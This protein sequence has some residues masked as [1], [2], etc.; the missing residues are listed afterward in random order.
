MVLN[1]AT[2]HGLIEGSVWANNADMDAACDTIRRVLQSANPAD[3][4]SQFLAR[5]V[6]PTLIPALHRLLELVAEDMQKN[7]GSV[8]GFDGNA[9]ARKAV[10]N[11]GATGSC[12]PIVWL[13]Q[14][15]MRNAS[16][17]SDA[18]AD[19]PFTTV[20]ETLQQ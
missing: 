13:A 3:A 1:E 4:D 12:H 19:H 7:G 17:H 14:Y 15:L 11:Y 10:A 8:R 16:R 20:L 2:V 6:F 18:L 5:Q 9:E